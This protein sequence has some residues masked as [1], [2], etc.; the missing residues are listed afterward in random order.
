MHKK[1]VRMY[2]PTEHSSSASSNAWYD[3]YETPLKSVYSG[4]WEYFGYPVENDSNIDLLDN[5]RAIANP[6][7]REVSKVM[8]TGQVEISLAVT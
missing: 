6:L 2:S 7:G 3:L 1:M 4:F 5:P 8:T